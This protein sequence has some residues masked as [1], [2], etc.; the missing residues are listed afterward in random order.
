MVLEGGAHELVFDGQ[1]MWITSTELKALIERAFGCMF[2][3]FEET[4]QRVSGIQSELH[5]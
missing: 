2:N 1:L 5:L 4:V 3:Q